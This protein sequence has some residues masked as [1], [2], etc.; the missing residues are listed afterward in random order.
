MQAAVG[1]NVRY[2]NLQGIAD[3]FRFFINDSANNTTGQ[4]TGT[5]NQAGLIMPNENPD[6]LICLDSAIKELYQDLRNVGDPEL[7]LDN[8]ILTGLPPVNS[9]L[10]VGSPNPAT[11]VALAYQGF[12]DG[13]QWYPQWTLPISASRILRVSERWTNTNN[14]FVPMRPA[15]FGL[16]SGM[17]GT[18][19]RCWETREGMIWMPGATQS[20]DLKIRGRIGYPVPLSPVNLNFE[21]TY[22]P[23]LDS[24][25]AI[26]AKMRLLYSTRFA[27]DLYQ[28]A[29][30][31]ESRLM[32]K[33]KLECVR[34]LQ[35][36]ENQRAE[37]GAEAVSDFCI[38]WS[39]L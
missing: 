7:I 25:N 23:I 3:L 12:F 13:V 10:G 4:G 27:P 28:V 1:G 37:F 26:A 39:W 6:L 14:D 19:M 21:T 5:G 2:G 30:A 8:Y 16:P 32:G 9:S 17:Q 15:P 35:A 38:A 24:T 29:V 31:E 33:L 22:V 36:F 11:Q 18:T 34:Q 20:V